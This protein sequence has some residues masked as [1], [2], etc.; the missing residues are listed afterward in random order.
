M[1]ENLKKHLDQ[2]SDKWRNKIEIE[3]NN[4]DATECFYAVRKKTYSFLSCR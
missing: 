3:E 2:F 1:E 4:L